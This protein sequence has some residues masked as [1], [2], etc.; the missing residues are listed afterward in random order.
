MTEP[1]PDEKQTESMPT[2]SVEA[3]LLGE[4]DRSAAQNRALFATQGT[5]V[6]NLV[7]SPGAGKTTLLVE[8]LRVLQARY[9][10]AVIEGDQQ[11][12]LDARRIAETGAPVVQVNTGQAC[13]L[14]G[15]MIAAAAQTLAVARPDALFIEN[16]G[17]LIC[18]A[19]YDLG[20]QAKIVLMSVTEGEE[21]PLKYPLIFHLARA[22][23]LTKVDLLPYLKFDVDLC[24][25]NARQVNPHLEIIQT[26][27]FQPAANQG[28]IDWLCEQ[29]EK[30]KG[31]EVTP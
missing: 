7:S 12:D 8:T 22:L 26:S 11:T 9:R 19:E 21:K 18:P 27:A 20:E 29:I 16:V 10:V 31:S 17:N 13:H 4:N 6:L 24:V 3:R 23:V 30:T 28:W 25:R 2:I 5:C 1:H 15:Q 14:D